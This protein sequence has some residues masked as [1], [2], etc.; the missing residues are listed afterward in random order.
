MSKFLINSNASRNVDFT[1]DDNALNFHKGLKEYSST[2]VKYLESISKELS[3][4]SVIVK[5]E[6]HRFGMNAFKILGAS[7]AIHK[8][9]KENPEARTFCTATDGNHGRAVARSARWFGKKAVIFMPQ[10]TVEERVFNIQSEGAKVILVSGDY[11][12]ATKEAII[13]SN[14]EDAV[15]IQDSSWE[16]YEKITRDIMSGY[17]TMMFELEDQI[18]LNKIEVVFL[19][20]GVGTWAA[21]VVLYFLQRNKNRNTKF[22]I[23]E[24]QEADCMLESVKQKRVD[25]SKGSQKTIMAGLNC[26]TP[27]LEAFKIL[28]EHA[29]IFLAINDDFVCDAMRKLYSDKITSGESGAAGLAALLAVQTD[30][31]LLEVKRFL[32]L[33]EDSNVLLF[34]TEGDTDK[35]NFRKIINEQI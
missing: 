29:N 34:N 17:L 16:G 20:C 32:S 25:K 7:Y 19:Q 24:P 8:Y 31:S 5:D 18:D 13:F 35:Q 15:L 10:H 1:V 22:V 2:P 3:I 21:A 4:G 12:L 26:G 33:N 28:K 11:D 30:P 9:L 14:E 27:A 6:S 23:V